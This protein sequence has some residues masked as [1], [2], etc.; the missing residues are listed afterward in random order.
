MPLPS[1]PG[2]WEH[3]P[4]RGQLHHV[5]PLHPRSP[6]K[7]LVSL[8]LPLLSSALYPEPSWGSYSPQDERISGIQTDSRSSQHLIGGLPSLFS[9]ELPS[10]FLLQPPD[11]G[12][13]TGSS[14]PWRNS[15]QGS[16]F[17]LIDPQAGCAFSAHPC[18]G[19]VGFVCLSPKMWDA[20]NP[21]MQD[22]GRA[23][24]LSVLKP[25][26]LFTV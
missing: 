3:F 16:L 8:L 25:P 7:A 14:A 15:R 2:R 24:V 21:A 1:P 11:T 22:P 13:L 26:A 4:G 23:L 17:Y 10:C 9:P 6:H 12:S 19:S 5:R 20:G 18:P